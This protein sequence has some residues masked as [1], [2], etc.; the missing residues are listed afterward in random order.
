MKKVRGGLAG[1]VAVAAFM[2]VAACDQNTEEQANG[3]AAPEVVAELAE[4]D[5]PDSEMP[6]TTLPESD[7]PDATE[8]ATDPAAAAEN[9]E[10]EFNAAV[11]GC[12]AAAD[13]LGVW[14][15]QP[16]AD[17]EDAIMAG[18]N[19]A[20]IRVIHPDTMVTKDFRPDRLNV[21]VNEEGN[22]T[23]VYCG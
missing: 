19:V 13:A 18:A 20:N 22:V 2:L 5:L 4:S 6:E 8:G 16:F 21:D 23:R 12:Q 1:M 7:L 17:A 15:G 14:V 3:E 11:A 9:G 10:A